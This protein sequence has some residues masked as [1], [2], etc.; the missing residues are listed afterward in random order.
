MT[1]N[2]PLNYIDKTV[3]VTIP[4]LNESQNIRK[5]IEGLVQTLT[6]VKDYEIIV[7]NDGSIDETREIVEAI[8]SKNSKI[9][10]INHSTTMGRGFS[11][12]EG[13]SLSTKEY[14]ICFNGK[15]DIEPEEAKKIF[16]ALGAQGLVIS[17]Q[18]NTHDRPLIRQLFSKL[19][20]FILN[21]SFGLKLSYYNGSAFIKKSDFERLELRTNS[22]ALDAEILI[23]LIKSGVSFVEIPVN[24]IIEDERNTRSMSP[25]NII[26]VVLFYLATF[27]E[28]NILR[29]RY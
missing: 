15:F 17:T 20:T 26:G 1:R 7:I 21:F 23:K 19:Y 18:A 9:T 11:I 8:S 22:Y 13:Y 27:Y 16:V 10:L 25:S 4:C 6:C 3:S 5:T 24:D 12:K 28:V 2:T 14:L 29:K